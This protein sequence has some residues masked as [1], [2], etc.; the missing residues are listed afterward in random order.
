[1]LEPSPGFQNLVVLPTPS[2]PQP[3]TFQDFL[4]NSLNLTPRSL[5]HGNDN[6]SALLLGTTDS[7]SNCSSDSGNLVFIYVTTSCVCVLIFVLLK[8]QLQLA[9]NPLLSHNGQVKLL[10]IN[11]FILLNR[12]EVNC[13]S[14]IKQ[15]NRNV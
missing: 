9:A 11:I 6:F 3:I 10:V 15:C 13:K 1:M 4:T 7:M 2:F 8:N 12:V 5:Q 14:A